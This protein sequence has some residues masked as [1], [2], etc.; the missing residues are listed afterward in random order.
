MF[1]TP[2]HSMTLTQGLPANNKRVRAEDVDPTCCP[3]LEFAPWYHGSITKIALISS[4]GIFVSIRDSSPIP[5]ALNTN[6]PD[7]PSASA[8]RRRTDFT[9]GGTAIERPMSFAGVTLSSND[10]NR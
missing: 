7:E 10:D 8:V 5:V 2:S 1:L 9:L 6:G 3:L 4:L